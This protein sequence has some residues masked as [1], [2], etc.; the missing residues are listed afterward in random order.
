MKIDKTYE[1][2]YFGDLFFLSMYLYLKNGDLTNVSGMLY[3]LKKRA[4]IFWVE[5][6]T[7]TKNIMAYSPEHLGAEVDSEVPLL[8][9]YN[10]WHYQVQKLCPLKKTLELSVSAMTEL[11]LN[12]LYYCII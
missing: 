6:P 2:P 12:F 8:A 5:K 1:I 4:L 7:G 11:T 9:S 3:C 10:G